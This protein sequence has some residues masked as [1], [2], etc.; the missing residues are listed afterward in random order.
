MA[1]FAG[2]RGLGFLDQIL[3]Q[4]LL[5]ATVDQFPGRNVVLGLYEPPNLP[6]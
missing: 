5:G 2:D 3:D 1:T 6:L 4:L